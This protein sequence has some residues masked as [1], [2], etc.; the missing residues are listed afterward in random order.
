MA[1]QDINRKL[2]N[3]LNLKYK[4]TKDT[5]DLLEDGN[6]IPFISR[7]RKEVT[8]ELDESQL[9]EL[10]D[11]LEYLKN[12]IDRKEKVIELIDK[13]DKLTDELE[14]KIKAAS[15]LQTVE[16]LYRPYRQKRRT[17]ATKAKEKGLKPLAES[18]LAQELESGS[19]V[20]KAEEYLDPE[21]D[22]TE[23][24]EI[25]QGVRDIIAEHVSDQPKIRKLVRDLTFSRGNISSEVIDDEDTNFL[26][27]H[28]FS[29]EIEKLPPHRTLAINRGEQ[30]DILRVR[31]NGPD[32]IILNKIKKIIIKN[33]NSIFLN[34]IEKAIEDGYQ[35]LVAP[36]IAREVR[37]KL[38]EEA[39]EHAIDL[40]ADNLKN[41]L[42]QPPVRDKRVL[43]IDPGFRTGSKVAVV[44]E[45]GNLLSI[46]TIYPHPPQKELVEAKE[47]I[48][49]L[50]LKHGVDII[51]I[52][53]GTASRETEAF[54]AEVITELDRD[55]QYIIVSEAGAS[56]Y[57]ASEVAQKEF[58][59]L[60]V[61]IRGAV[62]IARRLQDPLAE[63]VKIDPKHIGVGMYQHDLNQ[64]NL[65]KSLEAVVESVV[66]Y[67]GVD[68]NMA[69]T[70]LLKYVAGIN[71]RVAGN[72]VNWREEN[73]KFTKR[74]E[75]KDV[76]GVGPKTFTQAAGFLRIYDGEDK[77]AVTPIHPESY[78]VTQQ[79]LE[80]IN[81]KLNKLDLSEHKAKL[82]DRLNNLNVEELA[83]DL[84]VGIPTLMDIRQALLRPG[85]DPR[86][87]LPKPI[88]K[89][90]VT[91]LEDLKTGMILQGTVRN[92]VDFGA[93]VD[94]G[95]KDDGLVHI[96]ELSS[97]YVKD[98]LEVV[99]VGDI[100]KVKILEI[101]INRKRISL[102]MNFQ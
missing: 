5:V 24:K 93:F 76:Y 2:A 56:V 63:L 15:K 4:Q 38:T 70:S 8:G 85:R 26:D 21:N 86:E 10:N 41:L 27:Y 59:E 1:Q 84:E 90:E 60:D 19:V 20:D 51:V 87:E 95:V 6:T 83:E 3:K 52:G 28:E 74:K 81:F 92:V 45:I 67:V 9:R 42:L 98:P 37:S 97:E 54:V 43:A 77:L 18:F 102:T 68:L 33:Q 64:G 91:K 58:P 14:D 66:N 88:L 50:V 78:S 30:E 13:Q 89:Q 55:A 47:K 71:E 32:E 101:D 44:D 99:K 16:D 94:I 62:S 69:S 57:S 36:S 29:E 17:R 96:S 49:E 75:L 22:L 23:I 35:R 61:S 12:L 79:L 80:K 39:E 82:K 53:N 72:I 46:A 65:E 73:G 31:A 40:F 48:K 11:E 7:Y 34:Q 100:V 25:L